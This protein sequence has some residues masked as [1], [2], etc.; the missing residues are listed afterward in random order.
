MTRRG[1][2]LAAAAGTA[3]L[4]CGRAAR[5]QTPAKLRCIGLLTGS[6]S[7]VAAP[8]HQ[9]LL[10]GLRDHGWVERENISIEYRYA[11][12][13]GDRIP[14]LVADLVRLKVDVIVAAGTFDALAAQTATRTI[15]IVVVT[16]GDPVGSG[17][18]ES[19]ARPGGTITGLSPLTQEM[20]GKR[21]ELL[22]ELVPNLFRVAVLWNPESGGAKLHWEEL[23]LAARQLGLQLHSLEIRSPHDFVQAFEAAAKARAGAL[24]LTGDPAITPNLER[25]A[26]LATKSRLPSTFT[27]TE[28]ADSGGLVTYAPDQGDLF[29]RAATYVDKI[30][31]GAKPG[32]LPVER[33][34]KFELVINMK[35]AKTLGITIPQSLLLQATRVIE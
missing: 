10:Q 23:Q 18:V 32:D 31:K 2:L 28:F 26:A 5:G 27:R 20:A 12:G 1:F 8:L 15:P 16:A 19:L 3:G 29:R 34:T 7:A 9:A 13:I 4:A 33:S 11:K 21:L 24:Y 35:T 30:L 25:I 14:A 6:S 17:L 22:K